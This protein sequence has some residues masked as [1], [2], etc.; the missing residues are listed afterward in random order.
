MFDTM[1]TARRIREAR[2]A[3][4]LTQMEVAD[5]LGV[6]YQAV[7]NWERGNSMPDIGKLGDIAGLLDIS[8]DDM[9][10]R[11]KEAQTVRRLLDSG[12]E[13]RVDCAEIA[14]IFPLLTPEMAKELVTRES[15]SGGLDIDWLPA[16]VPF[17]SGEALERFA[18]EAKCKVE[19]LPAIAPFL[20]REALERIL[21]KLQIGSIDELVCL[22]PFL[23]SEALERIVRKM[24]SGNSANN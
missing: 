18:V 8:I 19:D 11:T 7:S 23:G 16:L 17:L 21:D 5:A 9:L 22:A 6:S 3:K 4:N 20:S 24:T 13:A 1:E 10:G 15:E 2:I 12:G 14:D